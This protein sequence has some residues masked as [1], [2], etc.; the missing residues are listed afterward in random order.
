MKPF[1]FFMK[2]RPEWL[3]LP[4]HGDDYIPVDSKLAGATMAS[5]NSD[6]FIMKKRL[7]YWSDTD[8]QHYYGRWVDE[9][10]PL[11]HG[12]PIIHNPIRP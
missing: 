9:D 4:P 11:F 10:S 8:N 1:R 2:R 7:I 5:Y 3:D 12:L 6:T